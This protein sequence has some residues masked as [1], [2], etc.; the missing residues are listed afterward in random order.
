M[1]HRIASLVIVLLLSLLLPAQEGVAS[2]SGG[3][4]DKDYNTDDD[5]S[6]C[7]CPAVISDPNNNFDDATTGNHRPPSARIAYLISVHNRRTIQDG[8]YLLKSLI[9]TS[10]PG[11][12]A[13]I[14]I[15]VD[16]RVGIAS[17][18]EDSTKKKRKT[19]S[20]ETTTNEENQ[21]LYHD[22]WL[23][24]YVNGCIATPAC[25]RDG[26]TSSSSSRRET[27]ATTST[28]TIIE[29]HSHSAPEWSKWSMNDPTLWAMEYITHHRL[30]NNNNNNNNNRRTTAQQSDS[31]QSSSSSSSSSSSWDVFI[32]LSGD[33]RP[34]IT[35]NRI[36]QLFHPTYGPLGNTNFLT[37]NECVTGLLPTSIYDFPKHTMKRSHYFQ[38]R[39]PKTINYLDLHTGIWQIDVRLPI[40]FGSQ[41]MSLTNEFVSYVIRSMGHPNGLGNVIKD[42]FIAADVS[43]TDETF[44]ATILMNSPYFNNTL[45][46]M[47]EGTGRL[48]RYPRLRAMR[49]ERMDEN[50]PNAWG[51]YISTNPLY[52]ITKKFSSVTNGEGPAKAWG[53]YF[54]GVYDLGDIKESGALFV[55][56][57]SWTVDDNLVR[58]LPVVV[59]SNNSSSSRDFEVDDEWDMLPDI[60]WPELGVKIREPFHDAKKMTKNKKDAKNEGEDEADEAEELEEVE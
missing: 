51:K 32:N 35:A 26:K 46:I 59:N 31:S 45:P 57:V 19:K 4:V 39:I 38:K 13:I 23:R 22:S 16:K 3:V 41:W 49:Y 20:K 11:D 52:D 55:R 12:I 25:A 2:G 7:N 50:I 15:H 1:L 54:L 5:W 14:L 47:S 29:V 8:A 34:V 30:L 43:M 48:A 33:T 18:D 44:F 21:Y 24:Q 9:E 53:P 27:N 40:Y 60:R 10:Y 36:S 56:K 28:T 17:R 42:I 37:G 6:N 58:L